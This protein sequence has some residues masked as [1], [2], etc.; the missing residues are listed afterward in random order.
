MDGREVGETSGREVSRTGQPG[1]GGVGLAG[2][3][4][5]AQQDGRR[6]EVLVGV[7]A[8]KVAS[9]RRS[10][11]GRQVVVRLHFV[12]KGLSYFGRYIVS[13]MSVVELLGSHF[14]PRAD[15]W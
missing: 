14:E 7:G 6:G 5:L 2:L 11:A 9:G 15:G 8:R 13:Y 12:G 4:S 1:G 3:G 10:S